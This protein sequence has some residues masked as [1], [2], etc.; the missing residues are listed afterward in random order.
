MTLSTVR[1]RGIRAALL[2]TSG[3]ALASC[4]GSHG[5]AGADQQIVASCPS[6]PVA[7][8]VGLDVSGSFQ[9][10][11]AKTAA[12]DTVAAEVRR[13]VLCGGHVRVFTFASST[14]ATVMLYDGDLLVEAPTENA[15]LRKASKLADQTTAT[16]SEHYDAALMNMTGNG[17]DPLGMLTLLQQA[18]A[19]YPEHA[20]V[21]VLLT[22]G[23]NTIG[24]DPTAVPD[25]DAARALADQQPVPELSGADVSIVGIGKQGTGELSSSVITNLTAFWE[26]VCHNTH[27]AQCHVSTEGR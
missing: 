22:D 13:A 6:N 9:S 27:A 21:N 5:T 23:V 26:Q 8:T 3:L 17:S 14:G 4:T 20:L 18:N 16:I 19:L 10:D 25:A 12:M 1:G 2:L 15:R 24:V 11:L 7:S